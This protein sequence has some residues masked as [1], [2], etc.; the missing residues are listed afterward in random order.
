M[1]KI[2]FLMIVFLFSLA[3]SSQT[4]LVD[5]KWKPQTDAPRI[6][7]D[8]K[9]DTLSILFTSGREPEVM[10]FSQHHDSLQIK[11]VSGTGACAIGTEGWYRI[12]WFSN[13]DQLLLR[14]I[15]DDCNGRAA[16]FT[17]NR[18]ERM[19]KVN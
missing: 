16:A 18:F 8:F 3:G 5:S 11:K 13:G 7:L 15:N 19:I 2:F 17:A 6:L 14:N 12:E 4:S 10:I 9:K 1:K